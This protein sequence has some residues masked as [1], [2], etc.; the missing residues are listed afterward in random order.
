MLRKYYARSNLSRIKSGWF[1]GGNLLSHW[2]LSDYNLYS[3][4]NFGHQGDRMVDLTRV[5]RQSC[6]WQFLSESL[7]EILGFMLGT[8]Q[9]LVGGGGGGV[10]GL[11]LV[12]EMRWPIPAMGVK[13][14]N[15]PLELGLIYHDPPPLIV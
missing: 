3:F 8:C 14:A 9:K 7:H 1:V 6:F 12:T 13:F 5:L 15:P 10:G 4:F 2:S 11:N